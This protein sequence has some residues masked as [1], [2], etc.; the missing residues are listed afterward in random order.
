MI[1]TFFAACK[2]HGIDPEIW[3]I[4]VLNRIHDYKVSQ[5]HELM[6]QNWKPAP[7]KKLVSQ[8]EKTD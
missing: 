8:Q 7:V 3:L 4:D 6:P 2:H 5:L 1:Y